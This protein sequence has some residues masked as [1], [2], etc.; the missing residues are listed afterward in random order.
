MAISMPIGPELMS[1]YPAQLAAPACQ[2]RW[3]SCTN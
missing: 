3:L 2:A 1:V